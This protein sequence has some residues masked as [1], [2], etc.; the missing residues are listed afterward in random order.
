MP[1]GLNV[2]GLRELA[3][4]SGPSPPLPALPARP[5]FH[6][7]VA[8]RAGTLSCSLD[9]TEYT[10]GPGDWLWI[11]PGQVLDSMEVAPDGDGTALIFP[12]GF[13]G[14]VAHRAI[15]EAEHAPSRLVAPGAPRQETLLRLLDALVEEYGDLPGLALESY[16]ETLR[17]LLSVIVMRLAHLVGPGGQGRSGTDELF[18]R[19]RRAVEE[20]FT[21][22]HRLESYAARLGYSPRT[23]TRATRQA[24]GCGAKQY[25]DDRVLLEAKRLL[26][27][28]SLPQST[29]GKRVGFTHPTAFSAFFRHRT[30]MTPTEFRTL[31][32]A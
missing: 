25:I 11:R 24:L 4:P 14:E 12:A 3:A 28:T 1:P 17:S 20:D 32:R 26:I 30:G 13:L 22:T 10:A 29:I 27:Y 18:D 2:A 23:L 9:F 8:V 7:L 31:T 6:L 16:V 19:F 5:A 21:R 15:R